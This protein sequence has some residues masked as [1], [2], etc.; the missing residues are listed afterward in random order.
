M[1][2][3]STAD[4]EAAYL[5]KLG[6]TIKQITRD[7]AMELTVLCTLEETK[8]I[9]AEC[10]MVVKTPGSKVHNLNRDLHRLDAAIKDVQRDIDH[11][12]TH[13]KTD[14]W[15][16]LFKIRNVVCYLLVSNRKKI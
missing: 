15:N 2:T 16:K 14:A 13:F 4:V 1:I 5:T 9:L 6:K 8:Q 10:K 12:I 3:E 11:G 7:E